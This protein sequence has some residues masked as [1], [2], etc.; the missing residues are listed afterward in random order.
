MYTNQQYD[1]E[2]ARFEK[3]SRADLLLV[4]RT[5]HL[6]SV[7]SDSQQARLAA[8]KDRLHELRTIEAR[9]R[10]AARY[11]NS[12]LDAGQSYKPRVASSS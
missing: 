2:Y 9:E 11:K 12:R 1:A 8:A 3:A 10:S 4:K 6:R 7:L 5:F